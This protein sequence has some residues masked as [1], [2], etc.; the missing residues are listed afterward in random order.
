MISNKIFTEENRFW[1][2]IKHPAFITICIIALLIMGIVYMGIKFNKPSKPLAGQSYEIVGRE[3][4]TQGQQH[5]AYN[6]NPPT[7]GPHDGSQTVPAGIYE[8]IFPD[9]ALVHS[10]EHGAVIVSYKSTLSKNE[11]E[12]IKNIFSESKQSKKILV[13]RD[14]LDSSIALTSWGRLMKLETVDETQILDFISSNIN[15]GPEFAP[16]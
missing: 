6:S 1:R 3:H 10:L 15:S 2:L 4:I 7:S 14:N 13:P 16:I 11:I 9:E 5:K 8:S 12:Q